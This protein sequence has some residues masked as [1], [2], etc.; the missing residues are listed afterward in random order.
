MRRVCVIVS[1]SEPW[2]EDGD[3]VWLVGGLALRM[4]ADVIT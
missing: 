1:P 4:L 2:F 3:G